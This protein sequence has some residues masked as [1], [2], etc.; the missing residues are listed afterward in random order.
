MNPAPQ[1]D[2]TYAAL[3][4]LVM[5]GAWHPGERIDVAVA[6]ER[7][8]ASASP[9]RESLHHLVGEGLLVAGAS[10]GFA[11]PVIT[12]PDLVDLYRWHH[13]LMQLAVRRSG[14]G[15]I[16]S[17]PSQNDEDAADAVAALFSAIAARNGNSE[18][19]IAVARL[20]ARL[21]LPRLVEVDVLNDVAIDLATLRALV[22]DQ[23][24][25][26]LRMA[27]ARYHRRRFRMAG[28]IVQQIHRRPRRP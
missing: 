7:L 19:V 4:R 22:A 21:H 27:L 1:F 23:R 15:I 16:S 28:R 3:K 18:H 6:S 25:A 17:N 11:M 10:E 26:D 8:D 14:D 12:E 2:R 13:E 20:G 5:T 24:I 9:I